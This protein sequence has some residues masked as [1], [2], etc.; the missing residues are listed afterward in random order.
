VANTDTGTSPAASDPLA[1]R[2]LTGHPEKQ[3]DYAI[4]RPI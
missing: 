3:I 2:V 1:G 4:D